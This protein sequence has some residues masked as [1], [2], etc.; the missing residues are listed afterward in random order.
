[1]LRV[2]G[3]RVEGFRVGIHDILP[4]V[5]LN[6]HVP[7]PYLSKDLRQRYPTTIGT[8]IRLFCLVGPWVG[9]ILQILPGSV[10]SAY[11]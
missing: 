8:E 10:G 11:P 2:S 9:L 5:G 1:M 4:P 7:N 6:T 3:L